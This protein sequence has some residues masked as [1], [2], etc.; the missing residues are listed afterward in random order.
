[1]TNR[2]RLLSYKT[3]KEFDSNREKFS[4]EDFCDKE[5]M[6]HLSKLFPKAYAPTDMHREVKLLEDD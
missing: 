6:E 4:Q 5:V 1:M 2:E 3:Y